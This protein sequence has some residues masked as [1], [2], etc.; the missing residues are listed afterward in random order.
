MSCV[1]N[2]SAPFSLYKNIETIETTIDDVS[3]RF[4]DGN[5]HPGGGG[6]GLLTV[7]RAPTSLCPGLALY[8]K[9]DNPLHPW[10]QGGP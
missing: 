6:G 5:E 3:G 7:L 8:L 10:S 4:T 1:Q 2:H 9:V